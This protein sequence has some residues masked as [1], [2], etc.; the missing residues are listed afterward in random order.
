MT[1]NITPPAGLLNLRCA[2]RTQAAC[3]FVLFEI[4][5]AF[6]HV[7]LINEKSDTPLETN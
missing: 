4:L 2:E 5:C 6:L 7:Q 1:E 3:F